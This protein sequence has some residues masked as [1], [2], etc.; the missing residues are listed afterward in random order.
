MQVGT[1]HK[2]TNYPHHLG[3]AR[4]RKHANGG[5]WTKRMVSRVANLYHLQTSP[6]EYALNEH[7]YVGSLRDAMHCLSLQISFNHCIQTKQGIC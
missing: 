6:P 2:K 4:V 3:S 1:Q 5:E 7:E